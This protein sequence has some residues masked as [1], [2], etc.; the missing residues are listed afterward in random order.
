MAAT[1]PRPRLT[2]RFP[3]LLWI[4]AAVGVVF[5]TIV[6]LAEADD[7][8]TAAL[9]AVVGL[10]ALTT[11]VVV[12]R[13]ELTETDPETTTAAIPLKRP[14][15]AVGLIGLVAVAAAISLGRWDNR[16][17]STTQATPAAAVNTVRDF[18][19]A[20]DVDGDGEAACGYLTT[21]LQARV[22]AGGARCRQ[23]LNSGLS[24]PGGFASP[25]AVSALR[26]RVTLSGGGAIA[27]VRLSRAGSTETFVL[28]RTPPAALGGFRAPSSAWRIAGGSPAVLGPATPATAGTPSAASA[29]LTPR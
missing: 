11:I 24:V 20:T 21:G 5:L 13:D 7:V 19:A 23:T 2:T 10:A 25:S 8:W 17:E 12:V 15:A 3:L 6:L 26:S 29:A 28:V 18:I 1:N 16:A 27:T 9:A 22:G 4:V 14:V